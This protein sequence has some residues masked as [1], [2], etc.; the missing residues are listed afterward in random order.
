MNNTPLPS[1]F[2][3]LPPQSGPTRKSLFLD[4]DETL[5][6]VIPTG[7]VSL[8]DIPKR[9]FEGAFSFVNP[10]KTRRFTV[11]KRQGLDEFLAFAAES[12]EVI[13]Y[14]AAKQHYA[15]AVITGLHAGDKFSYL[16]F[17]EQCTRNEF[18]EPVKDL[19]II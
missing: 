13:L 19:K 17:R 6:Q 3:S 8:L 2:V 10:T 4:L 1:S 11:F 14:T 9:A 15:E 7:K 12:F 18:D 16:L 5:V